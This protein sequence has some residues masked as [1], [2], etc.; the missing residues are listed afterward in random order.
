M[1]RILNMKQIADFSDLPYFLNA[2]IPFSQPCLLKTLD[3]SHS[4]E[5]S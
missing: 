1:L 3:N 5:I 4:V 2:L